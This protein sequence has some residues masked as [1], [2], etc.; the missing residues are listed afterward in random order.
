M[1]GNSRWARFGGSGA[2]IDAAGLH[3]QDNTDGADPPNRPPA[4]SPTSSA[5]APRLLHRARSLS[6]DDL[7]R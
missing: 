7:D 2:I 3:A 5:V 1:S 6:L 4:Q